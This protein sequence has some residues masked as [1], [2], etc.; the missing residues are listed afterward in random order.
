MKK[1][2]TCTQQT[3]NF[4]S[5][6]VC[7]AMETAN[8]ICMIYLL[9][10]TNKMLTVWEWKQVKESIGKAVPMRNIY[11]RWAFFSK[12]KKVWGWNSFCWHIVK[13]YFFSL[14]WV[15]GLDEFF[16]FGSDE[17][18]HSSPFCNRRAKKPKTMNL[19]AS[20]STDDI[21]LKS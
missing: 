10:V 9:C 17:R 3:G 20:A 16:G 2:N 8:E 15:L 21:K 13:N 14:L 18:K 7:H 6:L 11:H 12:C 4:S 1:K 5:W 19:H